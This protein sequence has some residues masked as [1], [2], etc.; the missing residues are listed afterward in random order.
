MKP[1]MICTRAK[2]FGPFL[3]LILLSSQQD[4]ATSEV[5]HSPADGPSSHHA[6]LFALEEGL[7]RSESAP[8]QSLKLGP[9]LT[10]ILTLGQ[11]EAKPAPFAFRSIAKA[12]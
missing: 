8:R 3:T 5:S 1:Q 2:T 10:L 12:S 9:I 4:K 7:S 6:D 11:R